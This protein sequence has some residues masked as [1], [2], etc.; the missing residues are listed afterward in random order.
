MTIWRD[1]LNKYCWT[2]EKAVNSADTDFAFFMYT[3]CQGCSGGVLMAAKQPVEWDEKVVCQNR[4]RLLEFNN[5]FC[6]GGSGLA[7]WN[8]S[9]PLEARPGPSLTLILCR[10]DCT[11]PSMNDGVR[12][13]SRASACTR[14]P[15]PGVSAS[16]YWKMWSHD[17]EA[18]WSPGLAVPGNDC[19]LFRRAAF[20]EATTPIF[21]FK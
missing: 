1:S 20:Q 7:T 15:R 21:L 18:E 3:F 8:L 10:G 4:C 2:V 16:S 6:V 17:R 14:Q 12:I 13:I 19:Q 5:G 11:F 9:D